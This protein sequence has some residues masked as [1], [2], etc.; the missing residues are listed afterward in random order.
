MEFLK[1]ITA[2]HVN[3]GILAIIGIVLLV[4]M[5]RQGMW[6]KQALSE[7]DG[8][9]SSKRLSGFTAIVTACFSFLF[10]TIKSGILNVPAFIALLL[11]SLLYFGI[12]HFSE[13]AAAYNNKKMP[14]VLNNQPPDPNETPA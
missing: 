13:I 9:P 11:T 4:I 3:Y 12:V 1:H 5:I 2:V 10:V 7:P 14:D 8:K 6:I